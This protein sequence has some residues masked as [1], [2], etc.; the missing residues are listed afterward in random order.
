MKNIAGH[1][2][3]MSFLFSLMGGNALSASLKNALEGSTAEKSEITVQPYVLFAKR[4]ISGAS[5]IYEFVNNE[6]D[7]AQGITN[8]DKG[9]LPQNQAFIF[10]EVS[11]GYSIAATGLVGAVDYITKVPA[12]LRNA[13]FEITQNGRVVLNA[14]V[15][16][17]TNQ[18]TGASNQDQWTPVGSLC[19]LT[20]NLDFT[21]SFKFPAGVSVTAGSSGATFPYVEVQLRGHRT[22]RKS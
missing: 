2:I 14:P 9:V 18:F 5:G 16:T 17:L 12:A 21:W 22:I 4:D 10:N 1:I 6:L 8:I 20:D 11:I 15:S 3:V 19:Y 13:E 7:K